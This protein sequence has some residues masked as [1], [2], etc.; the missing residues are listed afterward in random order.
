MTAG[1]S[2]AKINRQDLYRH[3]TEGRTMGLKI[4]IQQKLALIF[5]MFFLIFSGTVAILLFNVQRMVETTET[6]VTTNNK[7]D[8]LTDTLKASLLDMEENHKKL[9]ILKKER[10]S[11]YFEQAKKTFEDALQQAVQ[12]SLTT[13][14][15][16]AWHDFEFSYSRHRAG[17]WDKGAPPEIGAKW[18]TE[19]VVSKWIADIS[20]TKRLNKQEIEKAMRGLN[21]RSRISVRN[22]FY[23]FCISILVGFVG[24]WVITRSFFSPL[25]TLAQALKRISMDKLNQPINLK[26]GEEFYE[27]AASYNDM[28]RQL[29]EEENIRNEFIA[30]LSHE[31]RTPLSS[32][33]ESV[34]MIVEEVFGPV[35]D[36]QRKFLGLA[37]DQIQRINTLLNYLLNV[38]VLESSGRKK[39][40]VRLNTRQLILR[41]TKTFASLAAK[42]KVRLDTEDTAGCPD[43]FGVPEELQQVFV[44]IIG[45]AIKYSPENGTVKVSCTKDI[46]RKYLLF[47]VSDTGPGIADD[48]LSLVFTKYYRTKTARG[49]VDGVGLGLAI[50]RKIITSYGGRIQVA[51][52]ADRGC[53]FSFSLP[54]RS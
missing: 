9:N 10:Y 24:I 7:I 44:N 27:L 18:V 22:G 16:K 48:E 34:N 52:N 51:N 2:F 50:C 12:L 11:E 26:G 40:S 49:H 32:I 15:N 38:A 14:S 5:F 20:N 13:G 33:R 41:C 29:N 4:G 3:F 28:S 36:Q 6:I 23:G 1:L 31:I 46:K 39:K 42:K 37:N 54:T 45:N 43:L 35:N 21:E 25:K 8:E 53:T 30:T 17:L 19:L 47:Q